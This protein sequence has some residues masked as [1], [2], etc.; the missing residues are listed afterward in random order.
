MEEKAIEP[1]AQMSPVLRKRFATAGAHSHA[2]GR[3]EEGGFVMRGVD[4]KG[5]EEKERR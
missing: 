3:E 2:A 4:K 1:G 5:G